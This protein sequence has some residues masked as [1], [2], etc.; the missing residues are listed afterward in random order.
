MTVSR[1]RFVILAWPLVMAVGAV[2]VWTQGLEQF[3]TSEPPCSDDPR[4]TPAVPRDATYR[5]GAPARTSLVEPGMTGTRLTLSGTVSGV[6]CGRVA[7]ARVEIWQADDRGAY[8]TSGF[9]LRGHQRTDA[10]GAFRFQTIVPG[11]PT[12]RARH[13]GLRVVVDGKTDVS[14]VLFFPDD[15]NN[16]RDPRFRKELLLTMVRASTGRAATFDVVLGI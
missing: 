3:A 1:R 16:H 15:P 14:T 4:V 2:R 6:S 8:D 7:G 9:R 13:I 10:T 12:G 11:A 5:S